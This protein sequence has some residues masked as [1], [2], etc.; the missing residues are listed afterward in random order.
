MTP[1]NRLRSLLDTATVLIRQGKFDDAAA[2]LDGLEGEADPDAL[3]PLTVLGVPRRL[4]AV[5]LRL[6]KARGD[7]CVRVGLQY[8]LVPPPEMLATLFAIDAA[9]RR[10]RVRAAAHPVPKILHQV[11]VG[12]SP[13]ETVEV[14]RAYARRHG[15]MHKLWRE[16]DLDSLGVT[17]D[18]AFCAMADRG[19][20]PG[21]VDVARYAILAREGGVYLDCDWL[22]VGDQPIEAVFPMTGLSALAETVPRLSGTGSPFLNNSVVAAPPRHPAFAQLR[23]VLPDVIARLPKGPAWWVTGPLVFTL[24]ARAGPVTVLDARIQGG[25]AA[26]DMSRDEALAAAAALAAADDPAFLYGW[27]SW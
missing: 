13:P 25:Q 19:D 8:H 5:R 15:W 22:P 20:F 9:G 23:A 27:K 12:G 6:A 4:Q 18:P 10:D 3:G 17:G 21:A 1:T 16:P 2:I 26:P 24:A 14:W 7:A 11:W